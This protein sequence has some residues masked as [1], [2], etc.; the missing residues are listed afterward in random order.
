MLS[1][2]FTINVLGLA[3]IV[4]VASLVGFGFRHRQIMKS[5]NKIEE[6]EREILNNYAEILALEKENSSMESLLQDFQSPVIPIKAAI[7]D[8]PEDSQKSP[9]ISLR[10]KLLTREN[11]LHQN[12]ASK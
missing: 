3:L 8:E 11:L 7:K 10:K 1:I 5:R 9:D 2:E 4:L 6:L 12:V